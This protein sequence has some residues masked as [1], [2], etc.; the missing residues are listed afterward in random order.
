M[1]KRI[2]SAI[3]AIYTVFALQ[4]TVCAAYD[5]ST[6]LEIIKSRAEI[7]KCGEVNTAITFSEDDFDS[8]T[9]KAEYITVMTLP[10]K[11]AGRLVLGGKDLSAGQTITRR[12]L[13][14]LSFIPKAD[15][16]SQSSFTFK[17]AADDSAKYGVCTIYVLENKNSTPTAKEFSFETLKNISYKGFLCASDADGDSM[18]F[19]VVN[20][21]RHGTLKILDNTNGHFMYTPKND[22]AGRD[23][24]SFRVKDEYGNVSAAVKVTIHVTEPETDAVFGDML[25][26]WAH[27]SAIEA[28]SDGVMTVVSSDG[29]MMFFP[30]EPVTRGDFLA[31][32]MIGAGLESKVVKT[33][34]TA[35]SDD[36]DIPINIKSYAQ[37]ALGLGII[38]GYPEENGM[39]FDSSKPITRAEAEIIL[40]N[41]TGGTSSVAVM[42]DTAA[43]S[44]KNHG[45]LVGNGFDGIP[46]NAVIT[47][48]ETAQIYCRIK[49]LGNLSDGDNAEKKSFFEKL[50]EFLS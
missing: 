17:N 16:A 6:A 19:S 20:T 45:L 37:T 40:S 41:I 1:K 18:T 39:R 2:V 36:S 44:A 32:T 25:N 42:S 29:K 43:S 28:V 7:K 5:L 11:T 35:F 15:T 33:S 46:N 10:E 49:D 13:A 31:I 30:D 3:L 21:A 38:S 47:R 4:C 22:F 12:S 50:K 8:I 24:F 26:H 23:I 9:G 14:G 34:E 48:A 27:N